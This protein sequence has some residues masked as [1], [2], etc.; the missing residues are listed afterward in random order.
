MFYPE[1]VVNDLRHHSDIVRVVSGYVQLTPKGSYQFGLCP[2]H[3]EKSPSFSVT[4]EKQMFHCFGCGASGNVY[5]FI[6]QIERLNFKESIEFLAKL[7][8]YQLPTDSNE[9]KKE[10][11]DK[12][13]I[14][15]MHLDAT[16][17]YQKMLFDQSDK[18]ALEYLKSRNIDAKMLEKFK[19]GYATR[20]SDFLFKFLAQNGYDI[21]LMVKSGLIIKGE[22]GYF[23][24]FYGRVMFPIFDTS[25]RVIGF[26]GRSLN[27]KGAKYLNSSGSPI[28]YKDRTLYGLNFA[29]QSKQDSFILVEGYLDVIKLFQYG[30]DNAIAGLG[31][32]FNQNHA[33]TIN[34]YNKDTIVCYDND[35]AGH[36]ATEKAVMVLSKDNPNT[37]VLTIKNAKDPDEFLENFGAE[38][39]QIL[40]DEKVNYLDYLILKAKNK[41]DISDTSQKV[42][43]VKE[44]VEIISHIQN[45]ITLDAYIQKI[46]KMA[47]IS[48]DAILK[49]VKK[50]GNNAT[51]DDLIKKITPRI[52]NSNSNVNPA[53]KS[54]ITMMI[55]NK[56]IYYMICDTLQVKEFENT[57]F[58]KLYT[59][60]ISSYK[61][62]Q[63]ILL[64]DYLN[65]FETV[66]EQ[67]I[68][69]DI[70][71]TAEEF[72][73]DDKQTKAV[74]DLVKSIKKEYLNNQISI[75]TEPSEIAVLI[76]SLKDVEKI[77]F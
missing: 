15:Q 24:R 26:G 27:D 34:Q 13:Q 40:L 31:T 22:N 76:Q 5:T 48:K 12:N 2:F 11:D 17:L 39:F 46:S 33:R 68:V 56:D 18:L 74:T 30:F 19:V 61:N 71:N 14:Y 3:N 10:L 28:F 16:S 38:K 77:S 65:Y 4:P 51:D 63:E 52:N 53:K 29:K 60:I 62:N 57:I 66:E 70:F 73:I 6:M 58:E 8:N 25:N 42:S 37:K 7:V 54:I 20:K 36:N 49:E 32:A 44:S 67:R 64:C 35:D 59:Y 43:F 45:E 41:Y 50:A 9:S 55:K 1:N 47:D 23:D 75:Q 72:L 21:D 69:S